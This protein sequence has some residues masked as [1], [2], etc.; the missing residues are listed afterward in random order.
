[1]CE[2]MII[3]SLYYSIVLMPLRG[4]NFIDLTDSQL[5]RLEKEHS[6]YLRSMRGRRNPMSSE[7]FLKVLQDRALIYLIT[8]IFFSL[9]YMGLIVYIFFLN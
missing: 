7:Q 5:A 6:K 4:K 8:F 2:I 3:F 9:T 1:M